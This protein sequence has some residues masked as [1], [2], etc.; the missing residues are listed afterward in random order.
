[1]IFDP[2][3]SALFKLLIYEFPVRVILEAES[4]VIE[5]VA[6]FFELLIFPLIEEFTIVTAKEDD[7]STTKSPSIF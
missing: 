1:M 7:A 3:E 4:K 2:V 6:E 5:I